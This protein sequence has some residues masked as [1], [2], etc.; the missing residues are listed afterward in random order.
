MEYTSTIVCCAMPCHAMKCNVFFADGFKQHLCVEIYATQSSAI[1]FF[2]VCTKG[3]KQLS[4]LPH[5]TFHE[6]ACSTNRERI[7]KKLLKSFW[8][9]NRILCIC[10]CVCALFFSSTSSSFFY[11]CWILF[12]ALQFFFYSEFIVDTVVK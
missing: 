1:E 2:A 11:F 8:T 5:D 6:I 4:R 3:W 12:M 9:T 10:V 7:R